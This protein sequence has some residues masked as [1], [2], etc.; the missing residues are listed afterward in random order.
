MPLAAVS[1]APMAAD[2]PS[3]SPPSA[4]VA[5]ADI[6]PAPP[7][8]GAAAVQVV[9]DDNQT[10]LSPD[11]D[12]YYNRRVYRVARPEG[13]TGFQSRNVTWDPSVEQVAWH[14]LRIVR[15]GKTIDLLKGGKDL[16]V[17][18]RETNLERAMLDGRLTA[19]RQIEGLQ[20]G[21]LVD[22][23][24]TITRRD[25]IVEGHSYD[26]ERMQFPG[27]AGRYRVRVSWPQDKT[28][29]W[30]GTEGF[31]A[32]TLVSKNGWTL[33]E[34]D[35]ALATAPKPPL[36]APLRFQRLGDLE[37][38]SYGAWGDVSRIMHPHFVKAGALGPGSDVKVQAAVIAAAHREP[39]ERAFAALQLVEDQTRYLFLG[40]GEGGYVPAAADETWQRRFGDCKGKTVLLLALLN[41]LGIE[42]EPA[43]VSLGG[44]DGLDER[45]PSLS[46]FNHVLV[47]ASIGGKT[48]WLDG[49]R[50][51]DRGGLD[52]LPAPGW[53]WALPLRA[54]GAE[55]ERVAEAPPSQPQIVAA[56][57]LDASKGLSEAAPA[58]VE[59]RMQGDAA[60]GFRQIAARAPKADLER[61]FRQAF[62][63]SYSW[64]ELDSVSWDSRP[65]DNSFSL[66]MTGK[67]EVDWREN[68]DLGVREFKLPGG[69]GAVAVY[70]RREPGPNR[71]APYAVAFPTFRESVTEVV[72]P[73]GGR[74]FTIRG[75]NGDQTIGGYEV[76]QSSI[77]K[78]EVARFS[79]QVRAVAPEIPAADI[80]TANRGLR[81]LAAQEY[82]VRAPK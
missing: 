80:E 58:R 17:L 62:S 50:T 24:W 20:V 4:W 10:R 15:D 5:V 63:S 70:P 49:T 79:T 8:D 41:E 9:L 44:G 66:V 67:A 73:G 64:I 55:L 14:T 22:M 32:P 43:L 45:L 42:A 29:R 78:G 28:V 39:K 51:G 31:G 52:D 13:L 48:Y 40:M 59:L 56:I 65:G 30:Q 16:L 1:T 68:P 36:G 71:D 12:A 35:Q 7:E 21:D 69:G 60:A 53:R 25:P 61:T 6:P 23:A 33:L 74:G 75:P 72:L 38:S 34:R 54:A 82:F 57:R 19:S 11:G 26:Y 18:R 81:S 2:R 46:A 76:R 47:R 77:I 27:A 37:V 3:F